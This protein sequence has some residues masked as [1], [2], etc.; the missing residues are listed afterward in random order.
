MKGVALHS[1]RKER[2]KKEKK[3]EK[4]RRKIRCIEKSNKR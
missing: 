3:K 2:K 1:K 4:R